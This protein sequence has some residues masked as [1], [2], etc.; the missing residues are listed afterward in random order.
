MINLYD[1]LE[2]AGGQ[3]FGE[4]SALIFYQFC[5]DSRRVQPGDLF[6]ALKTIRGDGHD[7]IQEAVDSGATGIICQRPPE[8]LSQDDVTVI[9]VRDT[10]EAL[11]QWASY[12]LRRF[13]TTVVGVIGSAVQSM[14]K[15]AIARVLGTKYEVFKNEQ[16]YEGRYGLAL[17]LGGLNTK[18]RIAV[19]EI[20]DGPQGEM[21]DLIAVTQPVVGAVLSAGR[22]PHLRQN[23]RERIAHERAKMVKSLPEDGLAVLNYDDDLTREMARISPAPVMTIG[24]E[25]MGAPFGT[26]LLAYDICVERDR[27]IYSL[28]YGRRRIR[29]LSIPLL[30]QYH[31]YAVLSALTTGLAYGIDIEEGAE[32]LT[33]IEPLPGRMR[34][35]KG[36]G[37]RLLVDDSFNA[38]AETVEAGLDWLR[39]VEGSDQRKVFVIGDVAGLGTQA[40]VY[41]QMLGKEIAETADVLVTCGSMASITARAAIDYGLS[42]ESVYMTFS[43]ADAARCARESLEGADDIILVQ[44]ANSAHM[45]RTVEGLL[46]DPRDRKL[47]ARQTPARLDAWPTHLSRPT[48][49]DINLDALGHNVRHLKEIVGPD[50]HLLAVVK[51][52]AYGHGSVA[53]ASTALLNGAHMLGVATLN[54][55]IELRENGIDAPIL[56]LG[57]T[58][59]W[60]AHQALLH[61]ITPTL[62]DAEVAHAFNRAAHELNRTIPVHI[63]IDTGMGRLGLL[64]NQVGSFFRSIAGFKMLEIQGVFTHFSVADD[65]EKDDYTRMQIARFKEV[66]GMLRATGMNFTYVHAANSAATLRFPEAHFDMVRPGIAMYGLDPSPGAPLPREFRRVLSWKTTIAQVKALPDGSNVSYGN[67]YQ[68]KGQQRIAVIPVGYADGFRRSP[69]HWGDVLVRGKRA[70]IV[71]VV[72]MDQT[73]I[74]VTH[75][76][77]VGI[78]DEVVLIGA[79]GGVEITVEQ[80]ADRLGTI[81]YEVVATILARVPRI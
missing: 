35:V 40:R 42:R 59:V 58:P 27:T 13:G 81:P 20:E 77:D 63:K 2:A 76:P 39:T 10:R 30:G 12:I 26:D 62:Y 60:A 79:Q 22:G 29:N 65:P 51:A 25:T 53:A 45:E 57:Y 68:T 5:A 7:Y 55:A 21:S 50:V 64:P 9:V 1:L 52:N 37:N 15:E 19:L 38:T 36:A 23:T 49:V 47:L 33:D 80:V 8:N 71:G 70:P 4:P 74:D 44:G 28:R 66:L 56:I 78:G 46:E 48:W 17:S 32:A 3:L 41:H 16:S 24:L 6:V 75:I 61:N 67:T 31:L 34:P 72:T 11:Y 69:R 43:Q 18:H 14:A 54:E 73:M